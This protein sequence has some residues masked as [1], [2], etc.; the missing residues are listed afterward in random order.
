MRGSTGLAE[1]HWCDRCNVPL[2]GA[3]CG[4]C[5]GTG[6]DV[7]LSPP[8]D[9]RLAL[10]GTKRKLRFHFLK[11]YGVQQLIPDVVVLN[12]T[13]G[14]D[15]ADEVIVDGRRIALL[16]YDLAKRG[17]DIVLRLDGARMLAALGSRKSVVLKKAEGHM[18]GKYLPPDAIESY[19]RGIIAGDEV[20]IQMGQFIGCG[21]AKV[22]ARSLRSA[23]KGV[24]VR[25]FAKVGLLKPR[26][27]KVWT[28]TL[29]RAN[30]PHLMAKKARAEHEIKGVVD[31]H[32]DLPLTVSFSGGKDSLVVID[33]VQSITLDYTAMFIDT[34]LEHPQTRKYVDEFALERRFRLLKAHAGNAFD[35]NMPVFGPPAKDFRWCC[36]VCKL[37]P[38]S[39]L[40]QDRFPMGTVTVEGNRRLESFSRGHTELTEE[41]PFVP[42]QITVNPIRGWTGLDVWLYIIWRKL[43]YNP[44]YDEDLER[45]GCWMCPSALASEADEIAR[46]SPDL[47]RAWQSKL[48]AWAETNG[49]PKEFVAYGFWRWKELPPKMKELAQRLGVTVAPTRAD[50]LDLRVLKGVSPC[51]A[52]GYSVEAVLSS[53][54]P[55]DLGRIREMLKVV[56]ET[57][58]SE[59]FGVALADRGDDRLRI[60][61]GGQIAAVARTPEEASELF[62]DGAKA[63]LRAGKC[64][65]CGICAKSCPEGAIGIEEG[66]VISE[67]KCVR[68]G[69]CVDACVVAHY[70]D[71]LA[72]R[73][74]APKAAP[75]ARKRSRR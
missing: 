24:K 56:G 12:K 1:L 10:E 62:S 19:D 74:A 22:D 59:E 3:S 68:C 8:G 75:K 2:I 69:K 9:V 17:H 26:E 20:V 46:L 47:A 34:G 57:S 29:V 6:R 51:A 16:R 61:A 39:A 70:F 21:S 64:T 25:E 50:K 73:I 49:L 30:Q 36:K 32:P 53:E 40:I 58:L 60:F 72:G 42:G 66:V 28:K 5:G 43:R 67:E 35:H 45:V 23:E 54:S 71:K 44:L 41:N 48:M 27:K 11:E 31:S 55:A 38:V 13:S 7:P 18:K 63:V 4:K 33:L 15:R 14:E 37:A 65:K 52:G